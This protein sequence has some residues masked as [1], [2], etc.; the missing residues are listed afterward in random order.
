MGIESASSTGLH[1]LVVRPITVGERE[2][3]AA[4]LETLH[5][6]GAGLVGEVMRY[7]ALE[8]GRWCA[9]LGFG[10]GALYVRSRE[11]LLSW[12]RRAA[13]AQAALHHQQPEVLHP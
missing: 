7:V 5:L 11:D 6:L 13:L 10:S 1:L 9:L 8:N 4:N 2:R 12:K 3:F